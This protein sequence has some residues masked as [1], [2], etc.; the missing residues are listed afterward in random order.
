MSDFISKI[1]IKA[2]RGIN[3]LFIDNLG[4]INLL[5]GNNNSGKTSVLEALKIL[6]TPREIGVLCLTSFNRNVPKSDN[7]LIDTF[8]SLFKKETIDV[9]DGNMGQTY[10]INAMCEYNHN[11]IMMEAIAEEK[12]KLLLNNNGDE[13]TSNNDASIRRVVEGSIKTTKNK[14]SEVSTFSVTDI[15]IDLGATDAEFKAYYMPTGISLYNHCVNLYS[16]I[17]KEDKKKDYIKLLRIF[18]ENIND[19]SIV[20]KTIWIHSDI[21][22][23]MPLYA[24]GMGLQKAL[25][26][27]LLLTMSKNGILLIDEIE[28]AIHTSAIGEIFNFIIQACIELNIQL[29][30]TTHSIEIIDKLVNR[31]DIEQKLIRVITLTNK[32]EQ[33]KTYAKIMSGEEAYNNRQEYNMELRI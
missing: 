3:N 26:I 10:Y 4:V 15:N 8:L 17:V 19:I 1:N 2:Y 11:E 12:E 29:F 13:N 25:L 20:E 23:T 24:Y 7:D 18:D 31:E 14:K 6:S 22:E 28:T 5:V 33:G 16:Q 9:E 30:A 21:K 27:S 32:P